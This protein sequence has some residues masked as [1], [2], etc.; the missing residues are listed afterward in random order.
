MLLLF[1]SDESLKEDEFLGNMNEDQLNTLPRWQ[2]NVWYC[3]C[4]HESAIGNKPEEIDHCTGDTIVKCAKEDNP[5]L[6]KNNCR[7]RSKRSAVKPFSYKMF[8]RQDIKLTDIDEVFALSNL[9]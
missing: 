3:T 4:P 5:T 2:N 7:I 9:M 8:Q 6:N 1:S